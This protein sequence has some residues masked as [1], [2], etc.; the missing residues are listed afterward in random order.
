FPSSRAFRRRPAGP[1]KSRA[2]MR[3]PS[4]T[5]Y[6]SR[7]A[8]FFNLVPLTLRKRTSIFEFKGRAG[9]T[10]MTRRR[11]FDQARD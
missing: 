3:P 2:S 9:T 10:L 6:E 7:N 11:L 4:E 8:R 1:E 5:H